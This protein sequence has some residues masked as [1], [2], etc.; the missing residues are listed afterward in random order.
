MKKLP[1]FKGTIDPTD[2]YNTDQKQKSEFEKLLI[3]G[4]LSGL[5]RERLLSDREFLTAT[6]LLQPL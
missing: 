2:K 6:E 1:Q 3:Q 4:V 5:H